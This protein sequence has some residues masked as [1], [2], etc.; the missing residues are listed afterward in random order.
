MVQVLP[1][2]TYSDVAWFTS[3]AG[4][5]GSDVSRTL[6]LLTSG[7]MGRFTPRLLSHMRWMT[8]SGRDLL[9]WAAV[10]MVHPLASAQALWA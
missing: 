9:V 2:K 6:A 1:V 7:E 8:P 5:S 4:G 3:Q 10:K